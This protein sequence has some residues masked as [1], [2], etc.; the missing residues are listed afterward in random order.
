M[1]AVGTDHDN[2]TETQG[3]QQ[4]LNKWTRKNVEEIV[5]WGS[6][7]DGT[8]EHPVCSQASP[9]LLTDPG[10]VPS[11]TE[12]PYG[13]ANLLNAVPASQTILFFTNRTS[14]RFPKP[15]LSRT[16]ILTS[17]VLKGWNQQTSAGT[18]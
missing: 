11:S 2:H 7:S 9:A 15:E 13:L 5:K 8:G 3:F 18:L 12:I 1:F 6:R 14:K 4:D 16:M 10:D 17:S